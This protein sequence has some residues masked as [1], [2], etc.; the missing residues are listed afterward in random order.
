MREDRVG[1]WV[2][3]LGAGIVVLV[4][5]VVIAVVA[6]RDDDP[7]PASDGASPSPTS[8]SPAVTATPSSSATPSASVDPGVDIS[9]PG[10]DAVRD[11]FP[12]FA[13]AQLPDGWTTTA[14]TYTPGKGGKGPVWTLTFLVPD[15]GEVVLTQTELTLARAVE[16]YLPGAVGAGRVDLRDYGTG[17]WRAFDLDAGAGIAK[18][19][20]TTSVVV[21]A[22]DQETAVTLAQQLLT[23]EDADL[24]EAG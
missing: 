1:A 19:L 24:P 9:G 20:P 7:L 15:G 18:Q 17:F 2:A 23:M 11:G 3:P 22:P 14:A 6:G 5:L 13:P 12:A 21:S 16:R 10:K 8:S 4:I